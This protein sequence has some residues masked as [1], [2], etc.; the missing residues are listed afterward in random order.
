MTNTWKPDF[1]AIE[2][3]QYQQNFGVTTFQT[4]CRV[5]GILMDCCLDL[6]LPYKV[7]PTNTW[8]HFCGVKGKTRVDKKRS[9]QLLVK[10][11]YDIK[12]SDDESDAIGIGH[13]VVNEVLKQVEVVE[14]E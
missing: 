10:D 13:Y 11:W 12:V 7:C 5:Q 3:V 8:R 6:E 14:W 9:M 4:L 2:G 1:I